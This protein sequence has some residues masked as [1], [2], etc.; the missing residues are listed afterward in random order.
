[1]TIRRLLLVAFLAVS[2]IPAATLTWLAFERTRAAMLSEIEQ[3]VGRSTAAVAVD[4]DRVLFERLLNATTW[5]HLEVMQDLRLGD[6]DK[7]LSDFL[8]E[9]RARYGS[10]YYALHAVSPDGQVVASTLPALPGHALAH[11][12]AWP[13]AQLPGGTVRVSRIE[14]T[15]TTPALLRLRSAIDSQFTDGVI[16]DLVLDVEWRTIETLL[17]RASGPARQILVL[18]TAGRAVAASAGLR[19]REAE[20]P[21]RFADWQLPARAAGIA[22]RDARPLLPGEAIVGYRRSQGFDDFSGFGWTYVLLQSRADALSP[23]QQMAWTFA[24]LLGLIVL[25]VTAISL[26]IAALIARPVIALTAFTRRYLDPGTPPTPPPPG[27]GELGELN[28]SFVQLMDTLQR[29]QSTLTQASKL[30]ALGEI[31]ALLAH[32]VRTPLGIL[33]S[34]VQMLAGERGLSDEGRELLRIVEAETARLNRLVSTLLDG[35]RTRPPQML[36]V[37]LHG[38]LAHAASLLASQ[39]RHASVELRL[40]PEARDATVNCDAEQIT[41]VLLNLL[42]NALQILKDGGRIEVRTIEHDARLH[43]HVDDNGPG[44]PEE[45]RERIFEP[46]VYKREGGIGLGLAVVR[47]ILRQHGGDIAVERSALGGAS[48]RFWLPRDPP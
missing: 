3:G 46:F 16:G 7:R 40:L 43:V 41:Q 34:S 36:P 24:G 47:Q 27:P 5:T 25:A 42:M 33:R 45:E 44:V 9:M 8:M 35:A 4:V 6:L 1:M 28:R 15:A 20:V 18:D 22:V 19:G 21:A 29:S 32:E 12:D 38:L 23:V 37:D 26:G 48:F 31:T 10:V 17:D 14:G 13:P 11:G 39:L 30:A 2:L